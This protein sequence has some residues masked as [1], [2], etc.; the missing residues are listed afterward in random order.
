M[1]PSITVP[2][3]LDE[4]QKVDFFLNLLFKDVLPRLSDYTNTRISKDLFE[5]VTHTQDIEK[6]KA[7]SEADI[8][9]FLALN[10]VMA[11]NKKP[12]V[13]LYW[14][15][16]S[17]FKQ[18]LFTAPESLSRDRFLFILKYIRFADYDNLGENYLAKI[19]PFLQLCNYLCMNTYHPEQE[20]CIDE[21][22][23]LWK[24]RLNIR[25]YI[26]NKRSKYGVKTYACCESSSGYVWNMI[27]HSV[28]EENL[29]IGRN[30]QGI[31]ELSTSERI[32]VDLLEPLLN[33]AYHV[34]TDN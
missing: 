4:N 3:N 9:K 23:M 24:G 21:T 12:S 20:L 5:N 22:L 2:D 10:L 14:S 33:Q 27:T 19:T 30:I 7:V 25:Q 26:P 17:V 29:G 18:D 15:K 16:A 32:V 34:F 31:D 8:K 11:V 13:K 6:Q 28:K 1:N